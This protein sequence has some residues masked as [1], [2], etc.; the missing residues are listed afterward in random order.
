MKNFKLN[1][2]LGSLLTVSLLLT[3]FTACQKNDESTIKESQLN[4]KQLLDG[5]QENV[6]CGA[7]LILDE[8]SATMSEAERVEYYASFTP[9][10]LLNLLN[11]QSS[12]NLEERC[13]WRYHDEFCSEPSCTRTYGSYYPD[14]VWYENCNY[15]YFHFCSVS[16]ECP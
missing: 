13:S 5:N 14:R 3:L 7:C 2:F 9:N 8:A 10:E 15:E 4:Q 1:T 6:K 16:R 11:S 12:G